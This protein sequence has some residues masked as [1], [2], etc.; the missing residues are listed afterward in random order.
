[1]ARLE[2]EDHG[3]SIRLLETTLPYT[4]GN[5]LQRGL[6]LSNL[7]R[8][9]IEAS[10]R[11]DAERALETAIALLRQITP[12]DWGPVNARD[13]QN[14]V[15]GCFN[16]LI[17]LKAHSGAPDTVRHYW[18]MADSVATQLYGSSPHRKRTKL[19]LALANAHRTLEAHDKALETFAAATRM[20]QA[21]HEQGRAIYPEQL[22]VE[23]YLGK[24]DGF[25]HRLVAHPEAP[26]LDSIV[27]HY[28][29]LFALEAAV[30]SELL[31]TRS[32]TSHVQQFHQIATAAIAFAL[33]QWEHTQ[34]ERWIVKALEYA[35][36]AKGILLAE[37]IARNVISAR[38]ADTL[39]TALVAL[40]ETLADLRFAREPDP[41]ALL[42]AQQ[43]KAQL[44]E[45]LKE[46]NPVVF[47]QWF[48]K[49]ALDIWPLQERSKALDR[50][51]LSIV[52]ADS[53]LHFFLLNPDGV[54]VHSV[55]CTKALALDIQAMKNYATNPSV[56]PQAFQRL[57][58]R[59]YRQFLFPLA[60]RLRPLVTITSDGRLHNYP[61]DLLVTDTVPEASYRTL[62]YWFRQHAAHYAPSIQFLD[63]RQP[64]AEY[65]ENLLVFQPSFACD[66]LLAD[67]PAMD[68]LAPVD[69]RVITKS[70]TA[71][72]F[73][74]HSGKARFTH[75]ATHGVATGSL[76]QDSWIAFADS[77]ACS[78]QRLH[79]DQIRTRGF[80]SD[81]LVL[82]AC[83][84]S[85]G[86]MAAGEGVLSVTN[87]FLHAG[88]NSVIASR[89]DAN[90]KASSELLAHFYD[91]LVPQNLAGSLRD[92]RMAYLQAESTDDYAAHPFFWAGFG[93]YG[94][95]AA[96]GSVASGIRAW[97][98]LA[99]GGIVALVILAWLVR[100]WLR[101]RP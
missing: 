68:L 93:I 35:E 96:T 73:L 84:A 26:A 45:A 21:L 34:R 89:W 40:D 44:T 10:E 43:R 64:A 8:A 61:F 3:Q 37:S 14:Y 52:D 81:V 70:A 79:F 74:A 59:A 95:N 12:S 49:K 41:E 97:W 77:S 18:Q 85:N 98:L 60:S 39:W 78:H 20:L 87:G 54:A 94:R 90:P 83:Q 36:Y 65:R 9:Y 25:R 42:R 69:G 46:R 16:L 86:F 101:S 66:S 88:C 29:R 2:N 72:E 31:S 5:P 57:A 33:E 99:L 24:I 71:A 92:A 6:L 100:H 7:A 51:V 62:P 11:A 13:A 47:E 67:I 82:Q 76:E 50:S 27:S 56:S 75:L 32:R 91:Q 4:T 58:F 19:L 1:I 17:P 15:L 38:Q 53:I 55:P 80:H 30:R 22:L 63:H 28:D 23:C 48:A